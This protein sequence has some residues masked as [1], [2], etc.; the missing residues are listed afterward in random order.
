MEDV[1]VLEVPKV[2][3]IVSEWMGYLL[4]FENM[5]PSV[6]DARKRFLKEGGVMLP[7]GGRIYIAG[8][9]WVG[10]EINGVLVQP[11][12]KTFNE[13]HVMLCN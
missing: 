10:T 5:L 6:I 3:V 12:K 9:E 7:C 1:D 11:D 4:L 8:V 13:A 2:D